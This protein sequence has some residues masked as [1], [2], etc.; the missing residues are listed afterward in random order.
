[1][2]VDPAR[3]RLR[4]MSRA[5]I[6]TA[7]AIEEVFQDSGFRYRAAMVTLTYGPDEEWEPNDVAR[8]CNHYRMWAT[9]RGIRICGVW[10]LELTK[11]DRP[12]YH[13]VLFIPRGYTPP[14]P[15]KQGWWRKGHT[16][17]KWAHRPVGYIAKYASKG[18]YG[19]LPAGARLHGHIGLTKRCL[20]YTS[21]AADE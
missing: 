3:A 2:V 13:L 18:T 17:A 21:D 7:Q 10:V 19:G 14:L 1:M 4:R 15:D 5:V 9:R 12:H 8:L 6:G 11:Q 20:L 16:N